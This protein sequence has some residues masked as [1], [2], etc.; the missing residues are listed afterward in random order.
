VAAICAKRFV[1][2]F[3][4]KSNAS[5]P[6]IDQRITVLF[7]YKHISDII[8][9][10]PVRLIGLP[11][12]VRSQVFEACVSKRSFSISSKV[13]GHENP[14]VSSHP[15]NAKDNKR[16]ARESDCEQLIDEMM[17]GI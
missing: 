2:S 6:S 11:A 13:S 12:V 4:W 1:A 8:F 9:N 3:A 17:V 7:H 10:M 5:S 14:L 16:R 15:R